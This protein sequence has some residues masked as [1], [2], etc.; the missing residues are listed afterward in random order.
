MVDLL[1]PLC[2]VQYLNMAKISRTVTT[3]FFIQVRTVLIV[4]G[5][6]VFG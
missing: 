4:S 2:L 6:F 3:M 1:W 5:V